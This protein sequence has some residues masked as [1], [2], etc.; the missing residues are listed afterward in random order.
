M[1]STANMEKLIARYL[2]GDFSDQDEKELGKWINENPENKQLFLSIK[3]TWDA[4]LKRTSRETEELLRFY[5]EQSSRKQKLQ[6][7]VWASALVVAAVLVVG[8]V[9]GGLLQDNLSVQ[10]GHVESFTVPMGS[11]SQLTL[12]DGTK[13]NL[14]SGSRLELATDFSSKK[15]V[16]TLSGEGYFE[17]KSDTK[18]PFLLKTEKFDVRVT[19]TKFNISSYSNDQK[20][21]ATLTEGQIQLQTKTNKLFNLKPGQKIS[22]EQKSMDYALKQADIESELAWTEG[23]FIFKEIPFPDLIKRLERWYDVKIL[24]KGEAFD[25]MVYSGK[26]KNQETIWEV[27]EALKLTTPIDFKKRNLREF[28]LIYTAMK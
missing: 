10:P 18:H 25:A 27:L 16:V 28:E 14:N 7:P 24:Y 19:G 2:N 21:S 20:I 1:A 3:D 26:F 23:N 13:V 15:R 6:L 11:K 22:F 4:S 8:L 9:I 17:V 5:K 12:A